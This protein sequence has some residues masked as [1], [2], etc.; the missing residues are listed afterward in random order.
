MSNKL[1]F[2]KKWKAFNILQRVPLWSYTVSPSRKCSHTRKPRLSYS[3][4][5]FIPPT[6]MKFECQLHTSLNTVSDSMCDLPT[7]YVMC[8][9]TNNRFFSFKLKT[10]LF[11]HDYHYVKSRKENRCYSLN[12]ILL[13]NFI[14]R[15]SSKLNLLTVQLKKK[16]KLLI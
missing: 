15:I 13:P 7:K 12:L 4:L 10:K 8:L 3:E 16:Q 9:E 6:D 5:P 11:V 14:N 1:F 2:S